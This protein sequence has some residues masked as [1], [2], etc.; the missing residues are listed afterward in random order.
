MLFKTV[1]QFWTVL[2]D[3][4]GFFREQ[5][6]NENPN[7]VGLLLIKTMQNL[8]P[9]IAAFAVFVWFVRK[10]MFREEGG[11]LVDQ[12]AE[13]P[14]FPPKERFEKDFAYVRR[15]LA[16]NET[17]K[18]HNDLQTTHQIFSNKKVPSDSIRDKSFIQRGRQRLYEIFIKPYLYVATTKGIFVPRRAVCINVLFSALPAKWT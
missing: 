15:L 2:L 17:M 7:E 6:F 1:L 9:L 16:S 3:M 5:F 10:A 12:T 11:M 14:N 13:Y 8:P 18:R 4:T